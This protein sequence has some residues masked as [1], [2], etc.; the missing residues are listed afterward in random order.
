MSESVAMKTIEQALASAMNYYRT[1]RRTKALEVLAQVKKMSAEP[2]AE[3]VW[4]HVLFDT[5]TPA[6][7]ADFVGHW[8]QGED[9]A[10]HTIEVFCDQGMGDMINCLRYLKVMKD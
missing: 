8:W 7:I 6:L 9:L 10:G 5:P 3:R 2:L 4:D 1:G